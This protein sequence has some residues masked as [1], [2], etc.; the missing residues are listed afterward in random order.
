MKRAVALCLAAPVVVAMGCREQ[1]SVTSPNPRGI[2]AA[3]VD[4]AHEGGNPNF[5]FLPPMVPKPT[6]SGTFNPNLG[7]VAEVC[8]LAVIGGATACD[9]NVPVINLGPMQ[10]DASNQQ[11]Q[12]NW[13]TGTTNVVTTSTYRI[14]V[15][16]ANELMGFA[17]VQ[18]ISNGSMK[19]KVTGDTVALVDGRT[20]PIKVR[21]ENGALCF[22]SPDCGEGAVGPAGA[23]IVTQNTL[24]GA[25]FPPGALT[26][27][28]TVLISQSA[29]RPCLPIDLLQHQ[30]CYNFVTSPPG[31]FQ[32]N[33]TVAICVPLEEF[34]GIPPSS[35]RWFLLHRLDVVNGQPV[36]TSLPNA[37]ASF[38]PCEETETAPP[39]ST[40]GMRGIGHWLAVA[41]SGARAV[42][43]FFMPR[44]LYAFHLGVGGSTCCFSQV[45]WALPAIL[46]K[47]SGGDG[48]TA[49]PGTAV[50]IPPSVALHD[51]GGGPV[52]GETV[53]FSIGSGGGSITGAT[54][55][56]DASGVATIG[57]WTLG[58]AGPNTLLATSNGAV[59]SPQ[60]FTA[61][62]LA[63]PQ[64]LAPI[65]GALIQQNNPN[66]GCTLSSEPTRGFGFQIVFDWSDVAAPNGVAGYDL[67]AQSQ[68]A[69]LPIVNT[70][71]EGASTFTFTACNSFVDDGNLTGWQWRVRTRDT[72]GNVGPWSPFGSF[73]F[74][75]CRLPDESACSAPAP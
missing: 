32:S 1:S 46:S 39:P 21:I 10:Q 6:F 63:A 8:T 73:A 60:T 69:T 34:Q 74:A 48:Q 31:Q 64:L 56:T 59:G 30:G 7:P 75:P 71:V 57:S 19:N 4:G 29:S 38:L 17:D 25:L 9:P 72:N 42:I 15:F 27:T 22:N 24:A 3:I 33:V 62:A 66:I 53:T 70:F 12:V 51:S 28:V 41:R 36:V 68:N 35:L 16:A 44:K 49:A 52:V 40:I 47:V 18:P 5:F 23:T 14:Q 43:G 65:N 50:A 11:Y 13:N 58:A 26:N 45:G 20:L 37:P 2:R 67:V 54:Q 61:T 55:V